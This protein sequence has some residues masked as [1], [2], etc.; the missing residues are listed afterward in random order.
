MVMTG[1][2][3]LAI[4]SVSC[5]QSGSGS[6]VSLEPQD[7]L[8]L[9]L[10]EGKTGEN[11][12]TVTAEDKNG[13]AYEFRINVP[14]K[15]RGE[16]TIKISTNMVDRQVVINE[17]PTNLNV[18]AWSEDEA[19]NV[20]SYIPAN[21]TDTKLIVKLDGEQLQYVSTSGHDSEYILNPTNPA[22]G[23]T[24]EHTLYIYAAGDVRE[25]PMRLGRA[26]G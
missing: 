8:T 7:E 22:K 13:T 11:T 26:N 6:T 14:Y 2:E 12:F 17:T 24:N 15:H 1:T 20:V 3:T 25:N 16:N 9:L 21:G 5:Y 19:G 10:K 23:D 18:R 4:T